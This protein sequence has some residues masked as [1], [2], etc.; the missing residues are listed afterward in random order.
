[1]LFLLWRIP[2]VRNRPGTLVGCFF[3]GYGLARTAME[4]FREP[5]VQLGFLIGGFTMGQLLSLPMIAVG[6]GLILHARRKAASA[7]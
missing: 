7:P 2:A 5:D 3:I 6:L 4:L 1:M